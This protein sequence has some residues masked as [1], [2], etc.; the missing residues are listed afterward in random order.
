[1]PAADVRVPVSGECRRCR[2]VFERVRGR[3]R[4][5]ARAP[6]AE[7]G[8]E[9]RELDRRVD[10]HRG[11]LSAACLARRHGRRAARVPRAVLRLPARRRSSSAACAGQAIR[12]STSSRD[13][14]T[15]EVV[16]FTVWQALA[17]TRAHAR[18]VA[19]PAAYVLGRVPLPRARRL[20]SALV[21]VPFVLPTVVVGARVP[22]APPRRPRARLG[23]D[24]GRARVLQRRRRRAHRRRLLGEPRS[25]ARRGRRDARRVAAGARS[26]R[27]RCRC[28]APRSLPR[29]RSCSCSRSR[30]SASC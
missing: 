25:A 19:L 10:G 2:P 9:P 28:C 17:S 24:P 4:A 5:P 13:P 22:R 26:A 1:M 6:P 27:S 8:R 7:I 14:L 29:P 20:C 3:A 12:R 21:V 30:R 15:R 18:C 11:A 23:A 16:W